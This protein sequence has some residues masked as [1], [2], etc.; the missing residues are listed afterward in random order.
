MPLIRIHY[1]SIRSDAPALKPAIARL[2]ARHAGGLLGKRA[3]LTAVIVEAI[4]PAA[5]FVAGRDLAAAGLGSYAVEITVTEGTNTKA[6]KAAFVA[7]LHRDLADV[8]GPV[9][10][11]SYVHVVEARADGYGYGGLTQEFRFVAGSLEAAERAARAT[12]A[13]ARHGVR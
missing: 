4:D 8:L 13:V 7:A 2:V 9:H 3:D 5:W 1:A 12:A 6:E 10:A 11:E